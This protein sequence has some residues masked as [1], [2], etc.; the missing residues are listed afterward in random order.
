MKADPLTID[1]PK[2]AL[3]L[4]CT[5][6][7]VQNVPLAKQCI[8]IL[9]TQL[10]KRNVLLILRKM[11]LCKNNL[12]P[13]T[14]DLEP[15]APPIVESDCTPTDDWVQDLID[16]LRNNCLLEIDKN[17][18]FVLKQ[19][20]FLDLEYSDALSITTRDTMQVSTEILVYSAVMRWSIE[21][22]NRRTLQTQTINLKAVLRDLVY[23]PR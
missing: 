9:N 6:V 18:D 22:C 11:T 7:R 10:N 19:K 23:A 1:N 8:E 14:Y 4:F 12:I 21:E 2:I 20:E 17:G 5:A 3:D 15:S 16:N 13:D